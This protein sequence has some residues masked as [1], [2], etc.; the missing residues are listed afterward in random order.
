[1]DAMR[2][3][4][5]RD[6]SVLIRA[7][8]DKT[9]R[10][11]FFV[12]RSKFENPYTLYLGHGSQQETFRPDERR[13]RPRGAVVV[14][15]PPTA[16]PPDDDDAADDGVRRDDDLSADAPVDDADDAPPRAAAA[17]PAAAGGLR[18]RSRILEA[19]ATRRE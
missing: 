19:I 12:A 9:V 1:M 18:R 13:C 2:E 17:S 6:I 10:G 8:T 15:P 4:M 11:Q 14:P 7:V 16:P 3:G 5:Y